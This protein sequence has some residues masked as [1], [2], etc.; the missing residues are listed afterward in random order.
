MDYRPMKR[1]LEYQASIKSL[2]DL[3]RQGAHEQ[4]ERTGGVGGPAVELA[5][6]SASC[7][8]LRTSASERDVRRC[9]WCESST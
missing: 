5:Q 9:R 3:Q 4:A 8:G 1:E 7:A 6:A 2:L